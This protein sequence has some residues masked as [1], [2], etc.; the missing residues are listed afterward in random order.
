MTRQRRIDIAITVF[1]LL[2]VLLWDY[3]GGDLPLIRAWG[4]REGFPWRDH[5]LTHD[6]LH[7][8]GRI[9]AGTVLAALAVNVWR[10]LFGNAL[11][12][13][14]R[15][16]WLL[17]T[18]GSLALVP[19][20]KSASSTSCPYELVEFGGHAHYLS[21]WHLGVPDGG[22]GHCFPSGHATS[23]VAFFYGW[24]ALRDRHPAAARAWL[25]TVCVLGAAIGWAQMARGAHYA[26]HTLWSAWL[27]W[28]VAV[29]AA[30]RARVQPA[31]P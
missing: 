7:D 15:W 11:P 3:G 5:W 22:P 10:P 9:L 17:V 1:A 23:A 25:I 2:L 13:G 4:G 12:R 6:L 30:P 28:T 21:H 18:L 8:G 27:C 24:F 20:L 14:E 31:T 16:R 26:S 29:L 19:L